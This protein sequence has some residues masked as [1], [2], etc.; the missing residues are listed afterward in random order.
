MVMKV[1]I[2]GV[3]G[4]GGGEAL[5]LCASHPAFEVVYVA[6]ESSAGAKLVEMARNLEATISGKFSSAIRA[7]DG[8]INFHYVKDVMAQTSTNADGKV[9][10]PTEVKLMLKPY[11]SLPDRYAVT[12]K[13]RY[14]ISGG[15]LALWFD[16]FG[17]DEAIEQAFGDLTSAVIAQVA[18]TQVLAGPAPRAQTAG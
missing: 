17:V 10:L 8:S 7:N 14:R 18:P 16:L 3:S 1:G 9:Q 5:R 6:G 12:G 15:K 2:V 4:Y 13:L 11:E